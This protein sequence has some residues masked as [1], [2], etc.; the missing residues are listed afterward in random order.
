MKSQNRVSQLTLELYHRGLATNKERKQVENALVSD[1]EVRR[2]YEALKESDR[3][4]RQL[5][6]QELKRLNIPERPENPPVP[7]PRKKKVVL[8]LAAAVILCALIP[9]ILYF[10]NSDNNKDNVIVEETTH[11]TNTEEEIDFI[12]DEPIIEI[13]E[14]SPSEPPAVIERGNSNSRTE[15]VETPRN[16]PVRSAEPELRFD[17]GTGVSVAVEQP[18]DTG[19]QTRGDSA[20][21]GYPAIPSVVMEVEPPVEPEE[22]SNINIPQ[23]L[24]FIFDNMFANRGLAY[25]IIP[26]RI[27]SIGRNAFQGNPLVRVTI[28]ANVSIEDGA[29][30]GNFAAV[31]NAGGKTAGTYTRPDVNSEAWEKR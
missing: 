1:S 8:I 10:K 7:S 16:Q 9:A 2:R 27:T 17:P 31:Y 20:R 30:P 29:I 21:A 5:V 6:A 24:S 28:G 18:P 23:G 14:P 22:I 12:E 3:E 11:E 26:S 19:V 13:A 4:I 15:I 25:V